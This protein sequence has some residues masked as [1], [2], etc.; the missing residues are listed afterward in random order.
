MSA[1]KES[2]ALIKD[3][4]ETLKLGKHA[5]AI[6]KC[7]RLLKSEPKNAMGYLLLGAAYQNIDKVE[8]A[9]NLRQCISFTE[10]PATVALL[11]LANCAPSNELPEIYDQLADLQPEQSL[12]WLEKLFNLASDSNVAPFCFTVLKTRVK[13]QQNKNFT[14]IQEYLGRIWISNDFEIVPEDTQLYKTT[15]EALLQSS[16]HSAKNVVYKRYLKWL[17]KKQDYETCVRHACNMTESHPKDVYGFEWI[18]KTYCE[19]HEQS[20]KVLWQQEL[21]QPILE[22]AEQLLELN[23]NSNLALLVKALKLFAEGQLVASRQLALQAQKS[24][25]AYKETLELLARIHMELGAYKLALQLWQE[26]GQKN[27][28]YALC[29]SHEKCVSK[30]KEA[31]TILQ[32][33]ENSEGNIKSLAR[34]FFKLGEQ[35]LLQDLHLDELSKAE[36]VLTPTEALQV[37][38]NCETFEAHL[39]RCKL[40]LAMKNYSDALNCVLKATRLRPHFAECFDYLGRLYPL[41]NGDF[42]RARKCYEKC[43]N[44]NPLAEEAVDAL[45]YIYQE[46]GEEELNETLLLNTLSHLATD[47][48]IRLQ[49]KLGLHFLHVKKWDNAIQCFRIAIKNNSRC[50]IYW[51]SL[52]DAYA[53]RGSYNSAIRVFQKIL[54]LSPDNNY[55]LLQIALV[56]TTIRMYTESIEDFDTLLNRN[57]SYLPGLRGAA[58][59]HIG[60]ANSLK[61]QNLYGRSKEHLQLAVRHL[62]SAFLQPEAQGMVWLWRLSASIFVQTAQFPHSLANLDVAGNLAKREEPIAFLSQKDLLQLA[63]RFYLCA[64]KLKKNT[65]L[66][67]ELSLASYY[68]AIL[69]PE[70]ARS[71]LETATKACKMAIKERSNRWQNW[72]LLGVINMHSEYENLPLAQHCFIQAVELERKCYTAWT[73]LGVLYIK[74]KEVRLAN[75]AFTRAQQSSPVYTNAWIGQAMVAESIGDREEA[76]DLFRHCQ[77]FDYHPEAALGFAHWVCEMLSDP[78]SR[79]KPHIKHAISHMYGDVY[80]L[81]AINWYVQSEESDA[82]AASLSFQGFLYARKKLYQ[83]AIDAFTRACK[84]CEPGADRDK[85]YTNLGYLYLKIDQPEQAAQALNTVAHATFKPVIGLAQAYYRSGQLQESYSIYNSVLSNVVGHDDDKA[86]AILVAMASMIYAF[87]GEADT[88]TLLYQC[89]L[90]KEVPIQALYSALALGILHR[91]N[92]LTLTIMTELNAYAF[93]EEYC[94][95]IS[96]LTAYYILINEGARRAM[97]YLQSRIRMFPHSRSLR[98][99]LLK[100]LLDYFFDDQSYRMATSNMGL[101]A[102]SLGHTIQQNSILASEEALTTIYASQAVSPVNKTCSMKLLQRA[103]RLNPTDQRARQLLSVMMAN[104]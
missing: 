19:H 48:S 40:H 29:L 11:G 50:I 61:S 99:V 2:K 57:P 35:Q 88:K 65:Y 53:A 18:C 52:G 37:I 36:F 66:W 68:S 56:K 64:L 76:F 81:D 49:Y 12:D 5:E 3:I 38:G 22:Y 73:N 30:L 16:E 97:C 63:Q 10:G 93:K 8:A 91:D 1:G 58:E 83:Q 89:V 75:E 25:P 9:K 42:S 104:T 26:I 96:Y 28:A 80:A 95:D 92:E 43:I 103:I 17:Y 82:N 101:I 98:N 69:I 45:S 78:G 67:Y 51:E 33:L 24:H 59:A 74:L 20:E 70:N 47:E 86:A 55:A 6:P 72:N 39:L 46:L 15:I 34:C 4:R 71:H 7:Q 77:Q 32:T 23:P 44:L 41:A 85:L 87:Q 14:K 13:D 79:N 100:F 21:R 27:D 90:L 60:I 84:L 31:V 102:L 54:E 62:Q 94:A